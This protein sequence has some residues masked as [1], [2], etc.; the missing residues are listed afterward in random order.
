MFTGDQPET[1]K[2]SEVYWKFCQTLKTKLQQLTFPQKTPSQKFDK[3]LNLPLTL[4]FNANLKIEQTYMNTLDVDLRALISLLILLVHCLPSLITQ[5][6]GKTFRIIAK[7]LSFSFLW[8]VFKTLSNSYDIWQGS[9]QVLRLVRSS[10]LYLKSMFQFSLCCYTAKFRISFSVTRFLIWYSD[11][12][13]YYTIHVSYLPVTTFYSVIVYILQ[14]KM[15][16]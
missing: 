7:D 5:L 8:N 12:A 4:R 1:T 2:P 9:V 14:W 13:L 3:V 10:L 16:G 15:I 6:S 11:L